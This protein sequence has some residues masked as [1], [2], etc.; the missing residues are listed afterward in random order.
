[1]VTITPKSKRLEILI[2]YA[3]AMYRLLEKILVA[4]EPVARF[5]DTLKKLLKDEI[6]D[7]LNTIDGMESG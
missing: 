4:F 7:L 5:D 3:P 1:M 2:S 6:E